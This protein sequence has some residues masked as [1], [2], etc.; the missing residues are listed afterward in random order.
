[1]EKAKHSIVN[2]SFLMDYKSEFISFSL[3]RGEI[4]GIFGLMGA[5]RTELLTSIFGLN[6]TKIAQAAHEISINGQKQKNF[7]PADAIKAGLALVTE[8]RKKDGIFPEWSVS[9]NIS[10]TTLY[11]LLKNNILSV[12]KET[13]LSNHYIESLKI[14]VSSKEQWIQQLSGGNQQKAILAKWLATKPNILLLD[15]P[16]RGIDI[17]AKT[18]IYKLIQNLADAGLGIVM[19]SS[20]LPEIFAISDRVLV[21]NDG[22][23]TGDFKIREATE[24]L[25]LK[26]AIS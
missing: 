18:E 21:L 7:T 22:K 24:A 1:M 23:L 20:E 6:Q 17:N 12:P 5:G 8:D 25:L 3:K 26:A 19:V 4:L 2:D 16:T 10:I 11:N 9:K 13:D 15:E 14:K